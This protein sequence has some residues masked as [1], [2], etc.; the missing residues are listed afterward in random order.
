[1]VR[2]S[3]TEEGGRGGVVSA[4][5]C[6]CGVKVMAGEE[7]RVV[8]FVHLAHLFTQKPAVHTRRGGQCSTCLARQR[9]VSY[10]HRKKH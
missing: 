7:E 2:V 8:S 4:C 3:E 5:E 1:M 6:V 10:K 9:T